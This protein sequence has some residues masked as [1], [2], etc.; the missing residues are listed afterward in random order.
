MVTDTLPAGV[1]F[2]SA[3]PSTGSCV[4]SGGVVTCELGTLAAQSSATIT[5]VVTPGV[6]GMITNV[7]SVISN[8]FDPIPSTGTDSENTTVVGPCADD[9]NDDYAVCVAGCIPD[10]MDAFR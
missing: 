5:I 4:E 3:T 1:G 6:P 9:D 2:F 8:K 7:A 10:P